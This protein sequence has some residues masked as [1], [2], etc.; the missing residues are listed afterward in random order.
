MGEIMLEVKNLCV[1]YGDTEIIH[2]IS[3]TIPMGNNLVILGPNGCG[4][5]TLLRAIA[6]LLPFQGE[7]IY[8]G[9]K[10][11]KLSTKERGKK[12]AFMS[13]FG[14]AEFDYTVEQTVSMGRY[15]HQ[16]NGF[17]GG[18]DKEDKKIIKES[19]RI[20]GLNGLEKSSV[21]KLS[22]GQ[23]QRVFFARTLAQSPD[24]ILL[25]E[26]TNHLDLK[27]QAELLKHII[28]W[29]K[30]SN[31]MAIGVLHDINQG[32]YLGDYGI[33]LKDGKIVSQG[34]LKDIISKD[35]LEEVYEMDIF[36]YMLE[37][38]KRWEKINHE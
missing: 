21:M 28:D 29:S 11:D 30:E 9:I 6:G 8:Q 22:G 18:S 31:H 27:H 36:S 12:I 34:I 25:D 26:P 20:A 2:N 10:L 4:K 3:F 35:L 32:L 16:K 1:S 13:Q 19:I 23:L 7:I 33:L 14:F 15:P 24:M 37:S 5:T 17:F 38:L